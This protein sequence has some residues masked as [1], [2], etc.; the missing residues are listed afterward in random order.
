MRWEYWDLRASQ[1]S[2]SEKK[3]RRGTDPKSR[4]SIESKSSTIELS[5][6]T[7]AGAAGTG[8]EF[9]MR[10]QLEARTILALHVLLSPPSRVGLAREQLS[11]RLRTAD[12]LQ[13]DQAIL[14]ED[15]R[16]VV[17][18]FGHDWVS[19]TPPARAQQRRGQIEQEPSH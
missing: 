12:G 9:A 5:V 19:R 6:G 11:P 15:N 18:R 17:I 1:S 10:T 14:A 3:G 7:G 13:A 2:R 4:M 16:V 8:I